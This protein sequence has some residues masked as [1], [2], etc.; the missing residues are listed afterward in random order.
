MAIQKMTKAELGRY[1][2]TGGYSPYVSVLRDLKV[3]EG[4]RA[5]IAQEK[6]TK[7]TIK[8]RLNKSAESLGLKIKYRRSTAEDV[9]FEIVGR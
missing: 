3:G 6:C 4:G 7:Q 9:V 1:R 5:T 8:N 2:S